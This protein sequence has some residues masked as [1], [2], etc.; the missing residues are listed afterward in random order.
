MSV[1]RQNLVD[2]KWDWSH[3]RLKENNNNK[4][5]APAQEVWHDFRPN[6]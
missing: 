3:A 5:I 6:V 2:F 4:V 1:W